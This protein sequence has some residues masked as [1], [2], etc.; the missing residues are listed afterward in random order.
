ME[1]LKSGIVS[2]QERG[3]SYES[4]RGAKCVVSIDRSK[5]VVVIMILVPKRGKTRK[6]KGK[7]NFRFRIGTFWEKVQISLQCCHIRPET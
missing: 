1:I 2:P 7:V 6:A 3:L 4:D 5:K